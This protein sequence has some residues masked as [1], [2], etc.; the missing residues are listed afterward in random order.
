M[1]E[2][3]A[4]LKEMEQLTRPLRKQAM[5]NLYYQGKGVYRK[6]DFCGWCPT[7][8]LCVWSVECPLCLAGPGE[9]C[10][11]VSRAS[12]TPT[13]DNVGPVAFHDDRWIVASTEQLSAGV[14]RE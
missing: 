10:R 4:A 11:P 7:P 12:C 1:D 9:R 8:G 6:C 2:L 3:E 14:E 13:S 5:R